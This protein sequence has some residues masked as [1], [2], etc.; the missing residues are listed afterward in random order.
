M[1]K[2]VRLSDD[3]PSIFQYLHLAD[4]T[5]GM[6]NL[7]PTISR[8]TIR[9]VWS[10]HTVRRGGGYVPYMVCRGGGYVPGLRKAPPLHS[11]KKSKSADLGFFPYRI[12]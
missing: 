9:T 6:G 1:T 7:Q 2:K 5:L 3:Y 11:Q 12:G 10:S 4:D 8:G